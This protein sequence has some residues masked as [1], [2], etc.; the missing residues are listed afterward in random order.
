VPPAIDWEATHQR[1]RAD[2]EGRRDDL[3][4]AFGIPAYSLDAVGFGWDDESERFVCAERDGAGRIVGQGRYSRDADFQDA[5]GKRG[6]VLPEGFK[7]STG[8]I[9][10]V[11]TVGDAT[12]CHAAGLTAIARPSKVAGVDYLVGLLRTVGPG[13]PIIIVGENNGQ[14]GTQEAE[15][16]AKQLAEKLRRQVC[17]SMTPAQAKDV[18]QW[19]E[20]VV[21]DGSPDEWKRAG[22]TLAAAL[23]REAVKIGNA[24]SSPWLPALYVSELSVEGAD[25]DFLLN[26]IIARRHT[27]LFIALMKAGKTT[28][29]SHLL[30]CLQDGTEFIG[31]ATKQCRTLVVSEESP[32]IWCRRRDALGLTDQLS[33]MCRPMLAKPNITQWSEFIDH[34]A[35]SAAERQCDHVMI[36]TLGTFAPW[37]NENDAAEVQ[38]AVLPLNRLTNAGL[39]V[40]LVHHAGKSDQSHGRAARGS[41]ALPAAVD[42]IIEMRR[43][44]DDDVGD[45]RRLLTGMGRFDEIPSE[46]VVA[47]NEDGSGY[48]AEGDR[49]AIAFRKLADL[50]IDVLPD[51]SPGLKGDAIHEL[52]PEDTRPGRGDVGAALLQGAETGLWVSAGTGKRNDARRFWRL[53]S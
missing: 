34:V 18:R 47:L 10:V 8:S 14:P 15:S 21:S 48:T 46:L 2:I 35:T 42:I 24:P 45:R 16:V 22:T 38:A 43:F 40:S 32:G 50:I 23:L 51:G 49:R 9:L 1:C 17:W 30:R 19:F 27:T 41:T 52:L 53:E 36:D 25:I 5:K 39:A 26:G 20:Q 37:K 13:R 29:F 3:S 4:E 44:K 31:R 12:A 33:L 6:L 7:N 28:F 11:G